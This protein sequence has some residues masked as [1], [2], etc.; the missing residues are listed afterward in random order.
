MIIESC[1]HRHFYLHIR[2]FEFQQN[3]QSPAAWTL[4]S[5]KLELFI[6]VYLS[7]KLFSFLFGLYFVYLSL[8]S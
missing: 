4:N 5:A 6:T 8:F 7:F 1:L 3:R 2:F